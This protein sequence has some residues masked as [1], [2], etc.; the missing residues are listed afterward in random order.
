MKTDKHILILALE[1]LLEQVID[2]R[3]DMEKSKFDE[4][5]NRIEQQIRLLK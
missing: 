3:H 5:T 4:F 1:T 2:S